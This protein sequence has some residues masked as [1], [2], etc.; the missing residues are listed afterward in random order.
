MDL[1]YTLHFKLLLW[2]S[3]QAQTEINQQEVQEHA[4]KVV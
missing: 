1:S 4:V 3:G 2:L